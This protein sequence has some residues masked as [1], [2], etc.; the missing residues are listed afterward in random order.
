MDD[1]PLVD[2]HRGDYVCAVCGEPAQWHHW[3]PQALAE[4]FE[5]F[6][7]WPTGALCL[8]HHREWHDIVTPRLGHAEKI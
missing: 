7:A 5:D 2:D 8:K 3:A 6:E 1:V 4:R